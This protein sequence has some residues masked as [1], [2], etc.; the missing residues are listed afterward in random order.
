MLSFFDMFSCNINAYFQ[1]LFPT[2]YALDRVGKFLPVTGK[3]R[4][5][6]RKKP[7]RQK[8]VFADVS[9][10]KTVIAGLLIL[11]LNSDSGVTLKLNC[12]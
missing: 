8:L 12:R 2:V 7:S 4:F 5:F 10:K 6:Q 9:G 11:L 1:L 3:N